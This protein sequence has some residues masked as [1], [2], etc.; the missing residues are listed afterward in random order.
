M[1]LLP[2]WA[3]MSCFKVIFTFTLQSPVVT[4]WTESLNIVQFNVGFFKE[5]CIE[6]FF[7]QKEVLRIFANL[8]IIMG[9]EGG[10]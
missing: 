10:I 2:L 5:W 3:F 6:L 4:L 1:P 8:Y 7:K 9:Q